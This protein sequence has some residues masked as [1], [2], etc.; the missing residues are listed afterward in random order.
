MLE[1]NPIKGKKSMEFDGMKFIKKYVFH[2][3]MGLL[4]LCLI[5]WMY[6]SYHTLG[7]RVVIFPLQILLFCSLCGFLIEVFDWVEN[8]KFSQLGVGS[9]TVFLITAP[10]VVLVSGGWTLLLYALG[11][12]LIMF[13]M[14]F[15]V[16]YFTKE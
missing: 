16:S 15:F 8:K 3:N 7:W 1:I 10:L 12:V 11:L 5:W 6:D 2:P 13:T 14:F 9:F 4:I